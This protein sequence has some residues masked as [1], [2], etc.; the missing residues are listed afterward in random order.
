MAVSRDIGS[1]LVTKREKWCAA[2]SIRC[3]MVQGKGGIMLPARCRAGVR[4]EQG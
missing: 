3:T 1:G 2:A 4:D